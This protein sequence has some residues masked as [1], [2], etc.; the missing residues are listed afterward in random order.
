MS[1]V[2]HFITSAL[3]LSWLDLF[4]NLT[5]VRVVWEER[6]LIEKLSPPYWPIGKSVGDISCINDWYGGT[7]HYGWC[8]A[9]PVGPGIYKKAC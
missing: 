8:Y 5:Q 4:I 3:P 6:S 7:A 1:R 2:Q 9:W